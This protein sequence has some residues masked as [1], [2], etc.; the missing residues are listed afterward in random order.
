MNSNHNY[1]ELQKKVG[2]NIEY[3]R[4]LKRK[5]IKE[6][7]SSIK[8]SNTGCRNIERGITDMSISKLLHLAVILNVDQSQLKKGVRKE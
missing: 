8:L 7:A 3:I 6:I 2:Q 5:T 1:K 4:L